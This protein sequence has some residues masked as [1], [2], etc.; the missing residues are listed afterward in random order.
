MNSIAESSES[1]SEAISQI[2]D[3]IEQISNVVQTNS[4]TA[5]ESASIS[6]ELNGQAEILRN[7]VGRFKLKADYKVYDVPFERKIKATPPL[8]SESNQS[9][10][11]NAASR[12]N[13]ISFDDDY[14]NPMPNEIVLNE[15]DEN[16]YVPEVNLIKNDNG[17]DKY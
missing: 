7:L 4:A 14:S 1:Q 9:A 6:Q 16:A 2:R 12:E 3:G 17:S 15:N 11:S 8:V 13:T 5:E 10:F